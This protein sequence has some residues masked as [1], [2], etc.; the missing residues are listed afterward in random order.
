MKPEG[1]DTVC[2]KEKDF[3][4]ADAKKKQVLGREALEP[5]ILELAKRLIDVTAVLGYRDELF[6]LDDLPCRT[7]V[8]TEDGSFGTKG[9][10]LDAIREQNLS[11]DVI[12]ACGPTPMLRA[13]K[14]YAE[15]RNRMLAV[16]GGEDGVRNRSLPEL[17][18]QNDRGR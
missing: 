8:A 1:S 10:V 15:S 14:K 2:G 12:Y 6:L 5:R 7:V 4:A 3:V 13:L 16:D 9:N 11:A 18:L 17:C